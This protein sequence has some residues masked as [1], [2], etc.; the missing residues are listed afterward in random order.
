MFFVSLGHTIHQKNN[1]FWRPWCSQPSEASKKI[2]KIGNNEDLANSIRVGELVN[3]GKESSNLGRTEKRLKR[4]KTRLGIFSHNT[5]SLLSAGIRFS[6]PNQPVAPIQDAE[7]E[8]AIP[9]EQSPVPPNEPRPAPPNEASQA[10][11]NEASPAPI[12]ST[13]RSR[14]RHPAVAIKKKGK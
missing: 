3:L 11:P 5:H 6:Q 13:T 8:H 4:A 7:N 14:K 9:N 10:P 1:G 12:T 2:Q